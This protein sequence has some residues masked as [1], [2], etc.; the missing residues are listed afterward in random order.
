MSSKDADTAKKPSEPPS[1]IANY[2]ITS[3]CLWSFILVKTIATSIWYGQPELFYSTSNWVTVIQCGAIIEIYNSLVGNVKSPVMTTIM[4]V[5]SR[6]LLVV[7]IFQVLPYSPGNFNWSY[8]T[9]SIAWSVTEIIR[10]YYYAANILSK[11]NPPVLL[12]WLRYNTF[13]I[14]YPMGIGSECYIIFLSLEEAFYSVGKW[15]MI[16]LI[17][18]LAAYVPGSFV[19]YTYMMKQRKKVMR[20]LAGENEKVSKKE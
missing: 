14:L 19:L 6:L 2:N 12:T 5:A 18:C 17:L 8:I 9:L 13:I 10:Y 3:G 4:Q 20:K 11:G 1:W 16:F 7:G 15:Y